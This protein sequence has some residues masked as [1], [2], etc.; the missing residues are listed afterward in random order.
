MRANDI[1]SCELD[2]FHD[3]NFPTAETVSRI[4]CVI[5]ALS[6]SYLQTEERSRM[7]WSLIS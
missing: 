5:D 4:S 1:I 2:S 6:L 7:I 3:L